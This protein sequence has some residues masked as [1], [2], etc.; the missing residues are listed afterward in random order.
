MKGIIAVI[1]IIA[2]IL[3]AGLVYVAYGTNDGLWKSPNEIGGWG[4]EIILTYTDGT[5]KSLKILQDAVFPFTLLS[6]GGGILQ[7]ITYN[8]KAKT[9]FSSIQLNG[10]GLT[11]QISERH[12]SQSS[13][14]WVSI[15]TAASQT[16]L[17]TLTG[18]DDFQV[19]YSKTWTATYIETKEPLKTS[20]FFDLKF[21][22]TYGSF[23]YAEPGTS[24]WV[25]FAAPPD[26]QINGFYKSLTLGITWQV[27]GQTPHS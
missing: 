17:K 25:V 14:A 23:Q 16:F 2:I 3:I 19:V 26:L 18:G 27:S 22:F 5:T 20:G 4:Q 7:S 6:P 24:A 12:P 8:L 11:L 15:D 13:A 9:N 1:F 10:I 21:S